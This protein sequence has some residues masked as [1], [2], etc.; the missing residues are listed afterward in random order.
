MCRI[1]FALSAHHN[2]QPRSTRR[3]IDLPGFC[4]AHRVDLWHLEEFF[5]LVLSRKLNEKILFPSLGVTVHVAGIVGNTVRVGIDAPPEIA[6]VRHELSSEPALQRAKP[7]KRLNHEQRNRLHTA[8]L[9]VHLARKQL[10]AGHAAEAQSTLDE[11]IR[12]YNSLDRELSPE[13]AGAVNANSPIRVL[14]VEDNEN[15]SALLAEFLRLHGITVETARDGQDALETLRARRCPDAI[16]LDMRMPRCDGPATLAAI[17]GDT[18]LAKAKVYGVSGADPGECK[19]LRGLDGWF[20]KPVN[21]A[22]LVYQMLGSLS[23]N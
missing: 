16:L 1:H 17:R 2:C 10:Q 7:K 19:D 6:V 3:G 23:K 4:L 11:A 18:N 22:K 20:A 15:E 14:L 9:A 5:M 13:N 8:G 12:E 21:P